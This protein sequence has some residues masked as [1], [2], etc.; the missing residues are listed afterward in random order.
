MFMLIYM[1]RPV[2]WSRTTQVSC[3]LALGSSIDAPV[4]Y[5]TSIVISILLFKYWWYKYV[6]RSCVQC[7]SRHQRTKLC[8]YNSM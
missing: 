4:Y 1:E 3:G 5:D 7:F 8:E 6:Q 2:W